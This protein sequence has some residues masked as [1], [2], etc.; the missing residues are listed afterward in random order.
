MAATYSSFVA[1]EAY[2]LAQIPA[3]PRFD[4]LG[5]QYLPF[6]GE[7]V[8]VEFV[9]D[10]LHNLCELHVVKVRCLLSR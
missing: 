9:R 3:R 7:R 1:G 8:P 6:D 4:S 2:R 10:V 5:P